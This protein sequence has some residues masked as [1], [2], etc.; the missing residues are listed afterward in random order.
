MTET[1]T[2][3]QRQKA[4]W[5]VVAA[6]P[7]GRVMT[8]GEVAARAGLGRAARSIS[9]ALR[10]APDE[11][12]LPWHRV[13]NAKG[14]ISFSMDSGAY[15]EQYDLLVSEDVVFTNGRVNLRNFGLQSL[16]DEQLWA[17]FFK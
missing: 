14:E 2:H 4:I 15:R 5:E 13:I 12:G 3:E 16:V 9:G 8:Y 10:M 1:L 7:C 17:G 6:I 11:L